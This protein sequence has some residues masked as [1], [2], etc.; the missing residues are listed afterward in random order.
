MSKEVGWQFQCSNTTCLPFATVVVS[1]IG[2]CQVACLAQVQCNGATFY[3]SSSNCE[4]FANVSN[5]NGNLTVNMDTHQ[6]RLP[7][8]QVQAHRLFLKPL[9]R[10][11]V[12]QAR[13]QQAPAQ[14][15]PVHQHQQPRVCLL[16]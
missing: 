12:H 7:V 3:R 5:Q 9:Q 4:L 14:Q 10:Q 6:Q 13:V 15:A 8:R 11:Q 16:K 1:N 2:N